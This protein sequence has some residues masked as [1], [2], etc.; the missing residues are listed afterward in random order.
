MPSN[1]RSFLLI[2]LVCGVLAG[3]GDSAEEKA[4]AQVCDGRDDIATQVKELQGL[5]ITTATASQVNDNLKAIRNDLSQMADARGDLSDERRAELD[6]ANE[7][8]AATF[9]DTAENVVKNISLADASAQ[10][11]SAF[12]EL[13]S[14]YQTT[15]GKID[16]SD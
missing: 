15:L 7:A 14:S 1:A 9:R 13:A 3:C 5:T 12:K 8:F 6:K 16:C 11:E 4:T 2:P 10:L